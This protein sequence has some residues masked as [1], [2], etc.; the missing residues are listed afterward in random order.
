MSFDHEFVRHPR[1][2]E[3]ETAGESFRYAEVGARATG[4]SSNSCRC[5]AQNP[6]GG[7]GG[8]GCTNLL[9]VFLLAKNRGLSI[10]MWICFKEDRH[11][12][13]GDLAL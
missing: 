6:G 7:G 9:R 5:N 12:V 13:Q 1:E 11:M 4:E 2:R 8:S 3:R 10:R